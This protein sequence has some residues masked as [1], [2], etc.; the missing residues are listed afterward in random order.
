MIK[1]HGVSHRQACKAAHISSSTHRYK[2]KSKNNDEVI[3]KLLELVEK[4]PAIGFWQ[5][6]YRL[7]RQ[8]YTWNHK[9]V[10]KV[11]TMLK[12]NIRRRKK[13]RLPARVKQALFQPTEPNIVWSIDF[14]SDSLWDGRTFRLL[15][16]VDDFNRELVHIE[17]D[18]S[19][20]TI[21]LIRCLE[22][23]RELRGLPKMIRVDNG[24]E[25]I[26]AALDTWCKE[27]GITLVF[28]QPGKPMQNGYIERCNG[29]IRREFLN[30]YVFR[31]IEEVRQKAEEY[32]QDYNAERPHKSLGYVPPAEYET[33][34]YPIKLQNKLN[35]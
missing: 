28:I 16:I 14:M 17:P 32:R 22:M 1:E 34:P 31:T 18:L 7:R 3:D 13:K 33:N 12:L 20:P 6:H 19:L 21:R 15:N 10:Y 26:S 5:C 2:R 25:L 4:H 35:T 30:A 27:H 11:Y 8:G 29:S 24:P 23:L 9:R